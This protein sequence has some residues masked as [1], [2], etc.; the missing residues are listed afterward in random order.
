MLGYYELIF[1]PENYVF[2]VVLWIFLA[3]VGL[4]LINW[5]IGVGVDDFLDG[6]FEWDLDADLDVSIDHAM[7]FPSRVM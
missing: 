5:V 1:V 3:L 7:S 4:Q 2:Q 6:F